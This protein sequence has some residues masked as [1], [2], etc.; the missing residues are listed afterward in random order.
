MRTKLK[1]AS[2][3]HVCAAYNNVLYL[4]ISFLHIKLGGSQK[5]AENVNLSDVRQVKSQ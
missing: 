3:A 5:I 1:I 4:V 2:K